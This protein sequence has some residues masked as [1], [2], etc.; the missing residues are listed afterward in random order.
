METLKQLID[1]ACHI[2]KDHKKWVIAA[3]IIIIVIVA[4]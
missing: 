4:L 1:Q 3:A 2:W